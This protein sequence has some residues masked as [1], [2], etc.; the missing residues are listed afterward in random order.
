MNPVV[1]SAGTDAGAT[2]KVIGLVPGIV[3]VAV[4][5]VSELSA[6]MQSPMPVQP[7]PDQPAKADP[8]SGTAVSLT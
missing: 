7:P 3:K 2:D 6:G 1:E 4:T 5:V 8:E